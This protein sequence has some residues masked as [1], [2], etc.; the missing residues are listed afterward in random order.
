MVAGGGAALGAEITLGT[1]Y[2]FLQYINSFF[3]PT[4]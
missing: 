2:I 4:A 1:L 3:E